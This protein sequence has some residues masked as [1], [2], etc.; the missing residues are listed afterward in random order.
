MYQRNE[1]KE[2]ERSNKHTGDIIEGGKTLMTKH[3]TKTWLVSESRIMRPA[4]DRQLAR[5]QNTQN[6]EYSHLIR[7]HAP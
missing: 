2:R 4:T 5:R 1:V 6:S 3:R 7:I